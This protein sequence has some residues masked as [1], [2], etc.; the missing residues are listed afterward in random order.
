[1][2]FVNGHAL[3]VA[4]ANYPSFPRLPLA[5]LNDG[6]SIYKLLTNP[7]KCGYPDQNVKLFLDQEATQNNIINEFN[8]LVSSTTKEDTVLIYFSGHGGRFSSG[9]LQGNYLLPF[10]ANPDAILETTINGGELTQIFR[11]IVTQKLLVI[12]DCCH[13]GGTGEPKSTKM[14]I[15]G[16][17]SGFS[18]KYYDAL[19]QGSGRAIIASSLSDEMSLVLPGMENSLFTHYLLRGL[20]GEAFNHEDG[21]IRVLDLFD[22]L[23]KSVPNHDQRQHP[24]FKAEIRDNFPISLYNGGN[25]SSA[26]TKTRAGFIQPSIKYQAG[27]DINA[28]EGTINEFNVTNQSDTKDQ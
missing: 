24:F 26:D 17:K 19:K 10:D 1:M 14:L 5:V 22:F 13:S 6:K 27:R 11:R 21:V 15:T 7:E 20:G 25:A 18:D 9:S 28:P 8:K 23:S 4:V 3:I 2:A 12:F 16:F